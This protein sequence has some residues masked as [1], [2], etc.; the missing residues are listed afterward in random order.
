MSAI[1]TTE[2]K[3]NLEQLKSSVDFCKLLSIF[4]EQ[5]IKE[6]EKMVRCTCSFHAEDHTPSF[7]YKKDEMFF[8]CFGCGISGDIFN[9]VQKKADLKFED[10]IKFIIAFLGLSENNVD[11]SILKSKNF[12]IDLN[13]LNRF[14]KKSKKKSFDLLIED[15][16]KRFIGQR[17]DVFLDRGFTKETLDFFE[18][19]FDDKENRATVPIRNIDGN[20]IGVTGRTLYRDFKDRD[21]QKWK[22]YSNSNI[23]E[24]LFNIHNAISFTKKDK[25]AIIYLVEGPSDV[26]W[27]HQNGYCNTAAI[28]SNNLTDKQKILL[29]SQPIKTIYLMLDGDRGGNSGMDKIA[30]KLKGYF[31]IYRVNLPENKDPDNF[32]KEELGEFIKNAT[33]I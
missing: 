18:I 2:K 33:K 15:D 30:Q 21:I 26:M 4:G 24:N 22:H 7:T 20:L 25:N 3:I 16:I 19:G 31:T 13:I 14:N 1:M 9:Y 5:N 12:A 17:G 8:H 27:C 6:D 28:L 11:F 10:S 32:S 23:S 29:L